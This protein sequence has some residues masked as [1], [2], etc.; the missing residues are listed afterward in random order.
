[1]Q[2]FSKS[3]LLAATVFSFVLLN[4]LGVN[5][6]QGLTGQGA[7]FQGELVEAKSSA[8]RARGGSFSRPSGSGSSGGSRGGSSGGGSSGGGYSNPSYRN[9]PYY[10]DRP[11][12]NPGP[13]IVPLPGGYGGGYASSSGG[14][15]GLL[16]FLLLFLLF[17]IA[18]MYLMR[19]GRSRGVNQGAMAG[20]RELTNDIVTVTKLQIALLAQARDIQKSLTE[21][22]LNSDTETPEGLTEMLRET[23]LALMRTPENWTH[24]RAMSETVKSREAA[25]QLFEKISIEERSKFS[26]ETLAKVG[27]RIRRQDIRPIDEGPASFIVVTL[28]V[29]T[30]D[31]RPLLPN[32]IHSVQELQAALQR[33]GAVTPEYLL[34][35]ELLWSPQ[36]ASDSLT[37]DELLSEYPD[38]VQI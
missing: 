4:S 34:I 8:G 17:P 3:R 27:G 37:Y 33:I 10:N 15:F 5:L 16:V 19:A 26:A 11:Y 30:E 12:S 18:A 35:Y 31:D 24:V 9:D 20:N 36:D 28:L 2:S 29:G 7:W 1:M 6:Q 32:T 13:V 22:T 23:V 14:G 21:L 38:L 25:A